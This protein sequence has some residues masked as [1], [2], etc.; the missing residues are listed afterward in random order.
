MR[1]PLIKDVNDT[2]EMIRDTAE[3]YKAYGLN[4]VFLLP[5][6]T[7]GV[8]KTRNIGHVPETFEAPSDERLEKIR[9]CIL[10]VRRICGC[11]FFVR[12]AR[13]QTTVGWAFLPNT[14]KL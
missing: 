5:Y 7:L 4:D 14:T 10:W 2:D 1:M 3:F 11:I 12:F 6:H 8:S 9:S 13:K